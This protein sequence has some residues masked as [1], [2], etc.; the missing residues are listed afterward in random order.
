MNGVAHA[1]CHG[2]VKKLSAIV[3]RCRD[4]A[5]RVMQLR[6]HIALELQEGL[7]GVANDN[8]SVLRR[9]AMHHVAFRSC[10]CNGSWHLYYNHEI[11]Y[12][13]YESS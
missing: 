8:E 4:V 10:C 7:A 12:P 9:Q 6:S 13:A 11:I 2:A 1:R 3:A 5:E